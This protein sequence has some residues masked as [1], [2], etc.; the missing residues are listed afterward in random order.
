MIRSENGY[1]FF[2]DGKT[3]ARKRR[4]ILVRIIFYN[5]QLKA[6]LHGI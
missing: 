4:N 2:H 5:D 1:D 3:G 6:M